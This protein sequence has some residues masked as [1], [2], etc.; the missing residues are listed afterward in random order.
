MSPILKLKQHLREAGMA[1]IVAISMPMIASYACDTIMVFTDRLFLSRLD[2]ELMNASLGGGVSAMAFTSFFVGLVGF[3][4]A[5]VAQ[6]LGARRKKDCSVVVTQA[7]LFSCL[8]Y[9]LILLMQPLA[10]RLFVFAGVDA[11]QLEPQELYLKIL[12]YGSIISL[13]RISLS[14]FFSG[15]A[16]TRIVMFASFAAMITNVVMDYVLIFGK[17]GF[18]PLGIRGAAYATI[19]GGVVGLSILA[20]DYFSERNRREYGIG[21]SFHF[22]R[23]LA[24]K[25]LKFGTPTGLEMCLNIFA[26]NAIIMLFHSLGPVTATAATVVFNWDLVS[27]VPLIG[28]E[29]GVTSLVGKYMGAGD[30]GKA[31]HSV[32]SGLKLG[33][34]YSAVILVF[35]ILYPGMLVDTFRPT[36]ASEVFASAVPLA[37]FMVRLAAVYVM[38][39]AMLCVFIGALRGAGD[40]FWAMRT[41]VIIHWLMVAVLALV[42]RVFGLS[43]WIGWTVVV[44]FFLIF[45]MVV[46]VRYKKGG[47]KKLRMVEQAAPPE[48]IPEIGEV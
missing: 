28:I 25:L 39:E 45:S 7:L 33:M 11:R 5:L 10:H 43:P 3:T 16:R 12:L 27:F 9:P 1:E 41:S 40:T 34:L 46:F 35:F 48:L 18:P 15:I 23:A 2:P 29:I 42:L 30:P 21:A 13:A 24:G 8:A 20:A 4:T 31:H 47:W 44:F 14:G 32:M 17:C 36:A 19:L 38:V 22:D 37:V 26:F 6:H